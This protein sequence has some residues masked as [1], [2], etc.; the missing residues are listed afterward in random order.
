VGAG[1][2]DNINT[3]IK[4]A[5]D[6]GASLINM[7]LGIKH[8]G[9]GL[10][11]SEVIEYARRNGTTIVAAAGN[12]GSDNKYYP[13]ADPYVIAVGAH[14]TEGIVTGFS[15][16]GAHL[17]VVAPGTNIYSA[18]TNNTYAY[19]SGTSQASPFVT[20]AIALLKSAALQKGVDLKDHQI[21]Y[22]LKHTADKSHPQFKN[23]KEGFGKLNIADALRLLTYK[24]NY[25]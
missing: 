16:Y 20:G 3:G 4:W 1:L 21:K 22:L 11:H 7:S 23:L 13:G 5:V 9:G 25:T 2:V 12:D 14:D 18:F 24:I 8:S 19:S 15:T 17:T 6:N 10:P